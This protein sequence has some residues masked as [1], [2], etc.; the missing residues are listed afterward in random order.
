M[1]NK[2]ENKRRREGEQNPS[3]QMLQVKSNRYGII[4]EKGP[5]MQFGPRLQVPW[6]A[7]ASAVEHSWSVLLLRGCITLSTAPVALDPPVPIII[8]ASESVVD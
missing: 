7:W 5:R 2:K 4:S 3:G 6:Q 1:Q 8:T